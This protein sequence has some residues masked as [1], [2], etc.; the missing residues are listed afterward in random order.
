M[1]D[2]AAELI[3]GPKS[4]FV[5]LCRCLHDLAGVRP[6]FSLRE[7]AERTTLSLFAYFGTVLVVDVPWSE[8][9]ARVVHSDV[10]CEV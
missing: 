1:G 9:R 7:R 6:V 10:R 5:V 4:L 3:G 2:A 8:S